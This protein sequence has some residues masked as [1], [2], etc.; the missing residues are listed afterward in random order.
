MPIIAEMKILSL[1]LVTH[2]NMLAE[3]SG[4]EYVSICFHSRKFTRG[5]FRYFQMRDTKNRKIALHESE[6][7][8]AR[9]MPVA[10]R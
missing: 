4:T 9:M 10:P 2:Q 7:I 1:V 6:Q 8:I 5:G 3:I